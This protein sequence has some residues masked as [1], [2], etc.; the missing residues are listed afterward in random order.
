MSLSGRRNALLIG[1]GAQLVKITSF[2]RQK[3]IVR[4]QII[5]FWLSD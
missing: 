5:R 3:E 4:L 2:Y 1:E